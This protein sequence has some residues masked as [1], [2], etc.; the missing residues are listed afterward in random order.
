MTQIPLVIQ[1]RDRFL[2]YEIIGS[3]SSLQVDQSIPI[4]KE[5]TLTFKGS[6]LLKAADLADIVSFVID[7][8]KN[9]GFGVIASWL[10]EKLKGKSVEQVTIG[11]VVITEITEERIRVAIAQYVEKK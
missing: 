2:A 3:N 9:I 7:A 5:V 11:T 4:T 1:T 8:G 10:Y 6:L